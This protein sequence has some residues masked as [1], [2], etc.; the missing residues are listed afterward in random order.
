MVLDVTCSPERLFLDPPLA[1]W[2]E[3]VSDARSFSGLGGRCQIICVGTRLTAAGALDPEPF[4][5]SL[6]FR[7]S[8]EA[9]LDLCNHHSVSCC[10]GKVIFPRF[11]VWRA[12][13]LNLPG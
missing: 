1:P 8:L 2:R 3:T 11:T 10:H 4:R 13:V 12:M 5:R 7:L 9:L 6:S